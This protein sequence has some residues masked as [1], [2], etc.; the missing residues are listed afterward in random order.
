MKDILFEKRYGKV[1]LELILQMMDNTK[2]IDNAI[3]YSDLSVLKLLKHEI[4]TL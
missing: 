2:F 3:P 1:V 4:F